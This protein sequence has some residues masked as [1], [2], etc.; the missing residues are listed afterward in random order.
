MNLYMLNGIVRTCYDCESIGNR[1]NSKCRHSM[2]PK[3]MFDY[4]QGLLLDDF[5]SIVQIVGSNLTD[6]RHNSSSRLDFI[7]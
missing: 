7:N 4:K 3:T 2:Q 1:L 5:Q 6:G